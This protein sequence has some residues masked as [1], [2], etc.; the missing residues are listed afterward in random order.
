[1]GRLKDYPY[2]GMGGMGDHHFAGM[3]GTAVWVELTN[4]GMGGRY[5]KMGAKNYSALE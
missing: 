2:R 1:M 3:G 5:D 4:P